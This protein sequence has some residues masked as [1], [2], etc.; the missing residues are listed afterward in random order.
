MHIKIASH[1]VE[2][3]ELSQTLRDALPVVAFCALNE[4]I[5]AFSDEAAAI[6]GDPHLTDAGKSAKTAPLAERLID[7]IMVAVE[8]I[9]HDRAHWDK[10]ESALLDVG[11]PSSANEAA[12]DAEIRAWWRSAPVEERQRIMRE[13]EAAPEHA[14]LVRALLR[15]PVPDAL[16]LEKRHFRLLHDQIRRIENPGEA[17]AIETG[18]TAVD[19]AERAMGHAVGIAFNL[20]NRKPE[21]IAKHAVAGGHETAAQKLFGAHAVARAKAAIAAEQRQVA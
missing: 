21:D 19:W 7:R 17:V 8:N 3:P 10:R 15:S 4:N 1:E 18:R 9:E 12:R 2:L 13:V 20:M 5:N 11:A 16:D 14:E 6:G